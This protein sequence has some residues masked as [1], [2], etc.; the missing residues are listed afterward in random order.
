[1][2]RRSLGVLA[3]GVALVAAAVTA[4]LAMAS[5]SS[6]PPEAGAA[7]KAASATCRLPIMSLVLFWR[8]ITG[9]A[10]R[11]RIIRVRVLAPGPSRGAGKSGA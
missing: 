8:R 4:P 9:R 11:A 2:L 1:M 6:A 7:P 3:V 5:M 10:P